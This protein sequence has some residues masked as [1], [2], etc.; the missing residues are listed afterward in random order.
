[1]KLNVGKSKFMKVCQR[2]LD[3][4]PGT[5]IQVRVTLRLQAEIK[6]MYQAGQQAVQGGRAKGVS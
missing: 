1:M 4:E 2:I 6:T 5:D 3:S